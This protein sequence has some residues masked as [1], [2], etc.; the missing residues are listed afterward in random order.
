MYYPTLRVVVVISIDG[1]QISQGE[2]RLLPSLLRN[3]LSDLQRRGFK[4]AHTARIIY[5]QFPSV[6][7]VLQSLAG[8][9]NLHPDP[10][11]DRLFAVDAVT[12]ISMTY[13]FAEPIPERPATSTLLSGTVDAFWEGIRGASVTI[14]NLTEACGVGDLPTIKFILKRS[15]EIIHE[16]DNR[17]FTALMVAAISGHLDAVTCLLEMGAD[18]DAVTEPP[19]VKPGMSALDLCFCM[20]TADYRGQLDQIVASLI[21]ATSKPLVSTCFGCSL[22]DLCE[23]KLAQLRTKGE[24]GMALNHPPETLD[25]LEP[26]LRKIRDVLRG[27]AS[28]PEGVPGGA[29]GS[30]HEDGGAER[31]A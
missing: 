4:W 16:R 27:Q 17:G 28:L 24:L 3:T 7:D 29:S 14:N 9:R 12:E 23:K 8:V 18:G 31:E 21:K 6:E 1:G 19:H 15:P 13:R 20:Q 30:D 11:P 26:Q 25:R 22:V 10:D 2:K 5:A